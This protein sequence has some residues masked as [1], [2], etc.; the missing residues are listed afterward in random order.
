MDD[1]Q[2]LINQMSQQRDAKLAEAAQF[3]NAIRALQTKIIIADR[4]PIAQDFTGLGIVE[5]AKR[6]LSEVGE[7]KS[8]REIA[9]A[10]RQRGLTTRSK[11]FIPTVYATLRN[12]KDFKRDGDSWLLKKKQETN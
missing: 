5:A 1:V 4:A 3:D 2:E 8:T 7:A 9:D 6:W 10:I 11:D 12:S